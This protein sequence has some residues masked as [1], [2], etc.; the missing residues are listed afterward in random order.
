MVTDN[1][2]LRSRFVDGMSKAAC[3]VNIVTTDGAAGRAGLTVSAMSSVSADPI[4]LLVCVNE[5][6]RACEVIKENQVFCVNVLNEGQSH[7]S[8]TFAGR[9]SVDDKFSCAEWGALS[10]GSPVLKDSLANFDCA[11]KKSFKWGSHYIFIGQVEDIADGGEGNPLIYSNRAYGRAIP[12]EKTVLAAPD[13]P[14]AGSPFRLGSYLNISA[15]FLPALVAQHR[16]QHNAR[17]IEIVEGNQQDLIALL[18]SSD[19][20]VAIMYL[21]EEIDGIETQLLA[22]VKPYALLP[23]EH[24][25]ASNAEL[26]LQELSSY[27]MVS[28]SSPSGGSD[29]IDSLFNGA[30]TT[31]LKSYTAPSFEVLRG[32]VGHGLGYAITVTKPASN[33]SY[34]GAALIRRPISEPVCSARLVLASR[35]NDEDDASVIEFVKFSLEHF[36]T[37]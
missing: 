33:M 4:S 6:S 18:K 35:I 21:Q 2:T 24:P 11:L 23:I 30:G 22:E 14:T 36:R 17:S 19:L 12:M 16:K 37:L 27:P 31:P 8:D 28:L 25:L 29:Y 5:Q 15:F 9:H 1:P 10:T 20:D 32:M 7:I 34:D 13:A 3:T 26:S